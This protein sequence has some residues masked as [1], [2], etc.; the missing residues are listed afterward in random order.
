MPKLCEPELENKRIEA[1][2]AALIE[3]AVRG[4]PRR[5]AGGDPLQVMPHLCPLKS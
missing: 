1:E 4:R 3:E 2:T 5:V